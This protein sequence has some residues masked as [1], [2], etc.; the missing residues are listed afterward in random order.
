M[1]TETQHQDGGGVAT[2]T[3]TL[4]VTDNRT[5]KQYEIP[6]EDNTIRATELR[7]DQDERRRL[8]ADDLRPGVHGYRVLP[9]RDH[10]HR[11]RAGHPRV[12]RLSDRAARRAARAT[13]RSRTC[14]IHGELPDGSSST[15]GRTRSR[16]TRSCTRTSRASCRASATTRTRW[17]CCSRRSVRSRPSTPRRPRSRTRRSRYIQVIRLLGEDADAGRLLL[18]AQPGQAVRLSRQRPVVRGQ[19][20]RDD[21]QDDRAQVRA[22]PAARARARRPLHPSRRPRAELLDERRSQRRLI[23]GRS[24][25]GGRR[26]CRRAVRAAPRRRQRGGVADAPAD[27]DDRQHP[28]LH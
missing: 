9:L 27:R 11:R 23:A 26:R 16:S 20:P 15:S 10:V 24:V 3:D 12:P 5:G 18:P 21:L 1:T 4:T 7:N 2:A 28:G 17:G 14:S 8:R 13:S 25:L 19:L 22:R 6:I